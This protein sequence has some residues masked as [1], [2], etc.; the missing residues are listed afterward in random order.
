MSPLSASLKRR[1]L[2]FNPVTLLKLSQYVRCADLKGDLMVPA[3]RLESEVFE[4]REISCEFVD[5]FSPN[6]KNGPRKNTKE[7]TKTLS[8]WRSG[9]KP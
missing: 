2:R 8:E 5:R 1:Q 9:N 6:M 7:N 3:T 4:S